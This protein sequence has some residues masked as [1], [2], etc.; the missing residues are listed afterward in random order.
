MYDN[1]I[2]SLELPP[3]EQCF[4]RMKPENPPYKHD[5]AAYSAAMAGILIE[6]STNSI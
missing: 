4:L 1:F 6:T 2:C 3:A 5:I